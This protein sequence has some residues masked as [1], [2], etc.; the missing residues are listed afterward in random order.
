MLFNLL[1]PNGK[2]LLRVFIQ[3]T[4]FPR[5]EPQG[6]YLLHRS[7]T[8]ATIR[9]Y[10]CVFAMY[11]HDHDPLWTKLGKGSKAEVTAVARSW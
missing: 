9:A 7:K 3:F 8:W 5:I 4:V 1:N 11:G 10:V 6:H 2:F